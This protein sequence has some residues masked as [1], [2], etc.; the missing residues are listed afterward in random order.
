VYSQEKEKQEVFVSVSMNESQKD[1]LREV[2]LDW[3]ISMSAVL[4]RLISYALHRISEHSLTLEGLLKQYQALHVNTASGDSYAKNDKKTYKT[5]VRLQEEDY[6]QLNVLAEHG[7][8]LP[9]ELVSI[10]V[11]LFIAGVVAKNDIWQ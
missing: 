9:G 2:A 10:L 4:R 7:F 11:E 5:S 8:Y 3:G 1:F 6:R